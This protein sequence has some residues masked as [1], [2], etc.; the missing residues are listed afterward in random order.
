MST[1][2]CN[3]D[4]VDRPTGLVFRA[5]TVTRAFRELCRRTENMPIQDR[6]RLFRARHR[7]ASRSTARETRRDVDDG[8]QAYRLW[9]QD[10]MTAAADT[11]RTGYSGPY[12]DE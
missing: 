7:Q 3:E 9:N 1:E 4:F 2:L 12:F 10:C 8:L 11:R 5:G 6:Q